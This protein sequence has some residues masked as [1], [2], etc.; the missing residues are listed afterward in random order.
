MD[1]DDDDSGALYVEVQFTSGLILCLPLK[2]LT[3]F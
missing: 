2:W 3:D 1:D